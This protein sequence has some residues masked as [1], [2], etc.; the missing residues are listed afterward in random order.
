VGQRKALVIGG[1]GTITG[2][3]INGVGAKH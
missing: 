1:G 2:R 3:Y